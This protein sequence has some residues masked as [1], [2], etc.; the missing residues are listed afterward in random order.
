[1]KVVLC[2]HVEHL[3]ERGEIVSVAAGYARNF[4]LPKRLAMQAT[5][6]N[7]RTLEQQR[8]VW[9]VKEA[10]A[11][12]EARAAAERLSAIAL[13][14]TKKA[15]E[16]GTLF[17]SVTSS[18][19]A[20]LLAAKGVEIDRRKIQLAEPIKTV[21]EHS[22]GIKLHRQVVAQVKLEVL[23]E[24]ELLPKAAPREERDPDHELELDDD[25]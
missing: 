6:G 2:D 19:I 11:V 25:E 18:E 24:Q 5:P 4:L 13:S 1:M 16:T 20:E 12:E 17:G 23:N 8:R 10:R 22:I 14:T 15:G 3:G 21:G 7:L 9:E